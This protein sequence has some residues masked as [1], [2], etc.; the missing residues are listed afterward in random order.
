MSSRRVGSNSGRTMRCL[1]VHCIGVSMYVYERE[2]GN[3]DNDR[4][5]FADEFWDRVAVGAGQFRVG[6]RIGL[7]PPEPDGL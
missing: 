4:A 5:N 6:R 7:R 1:T 2:G 3:L